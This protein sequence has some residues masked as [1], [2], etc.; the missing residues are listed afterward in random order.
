MQ[1]VG[2][3]VCMKRAYAGTNEAYCSDFFAS[4]HRYARTRSPSPDPSRL[5]HQSIKQL[6]HNPAIATAAI[7]KSACRTGSHRAFLCSIKYHYQNIR[8]GSILCSPSP[9]TAYEP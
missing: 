1:W 7:A 2:M 5:L 4:L 6:V 9:S 8:V 3:S